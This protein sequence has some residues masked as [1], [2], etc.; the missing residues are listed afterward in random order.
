MKI[1]LVDDE[2]PMLD[3]I[4]YLLGK[5]ADVQVLAAFLHPLRAVAFIEESI[6]Q[7]DSLPDA[8]F[9]DIDMPQI[10]GLETALKLQV[11]HPSILIVFVTA[12]SSYALESFQVH[13]LDYLLKPVKESQFNQTIEYIRK[14]VQLLQY[15]H[16]N[17]KK[18]MYIKCFGCFQIDLPHEEEI[19]WGTRRVK[20]LFM[21]LIDRDETPATHNELITAVFGGVNDRKTANNLYVTIYK[22]RQLLQRIDPNQ[23]YLRLKPDMVLKVV[24]G[25]CDYTDFMRFARQNP[26]IH[27]DN[28]QAAA[29]VLK[30]CRG[31][32]LPDIDSSWSEQTASAVEVEYERIALGLALFYVNAGRSPEAEKVLLNL[33][34]RNPLSE[35]G[36]TSLLDIY[37]LNN[38]RQDYVLI[39]QQYINMLKKELNVKPPVKYS[40]YHKWTRKA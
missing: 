17:R 37:I 6:A 2:Q 27:S 38:N 8:V 31:S 16:E 21:Y 32:Y 14:Q 34:V 24:P 10:N 13:P 30:L 33:I 29:A 35:E 40:S 3:E 9:M 18:S 1:M 39:Y 5:Y 25:V 23:E 11:L 4:S 19:K 7:G 28:A 22:L 20:E 26:L 36:Y 15:N 12:Y